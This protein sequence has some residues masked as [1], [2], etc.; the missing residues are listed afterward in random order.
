MHILIKDIKD[1]HR[2]R[3]AY[4]WERERERERERE[5]ILQ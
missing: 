3:L 1:M 4:S 5:I 2:I